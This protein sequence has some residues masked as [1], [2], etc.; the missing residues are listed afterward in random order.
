MRYRLVDE[1]VF[2]IVFW[3]SFLVQEGSSIV[4]VIV[5][6]PTCYNTAPPREMG[7][8]DLLRQVDFLL[9]KMP[10]TPTME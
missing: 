4:I 6:P 7:M 2:I 8:L 10:Y 3:L 5:R 1:P 9:R